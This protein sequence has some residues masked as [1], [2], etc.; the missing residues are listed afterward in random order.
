MASFRIGRLCESKGLVLPVSLKL[1][2]SSIS[3]G[4]GIDMK[5]M[6]FFSSLFASTFFLLF[7]PLS[8]A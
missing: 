1:N 3:F 2:V 6:R 8:F 7:A 5:L 4:E